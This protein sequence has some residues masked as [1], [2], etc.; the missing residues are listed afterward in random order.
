MNTP[1]STPATHFKLM[2][3]NFRVQSINIENYH[4]R[5]INKVWEDQ[6][7]PLFKIVP[8]AIG[9]IIHIECSYIIDMVE[10]AGGKIVL[11]VSKV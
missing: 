2:V 4:D 9:S 11:W 7:L 1:A 8:P 6:Y 10:Y 5:D 3:R